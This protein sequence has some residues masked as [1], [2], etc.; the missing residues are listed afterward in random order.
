M[1]SKHD[2]NIAKNDIDVAKNTP[3]VVSSLSWFKGAK[4]VLGTGSLW[5]KC[6]QARGR[7][8]GITQS[9]WRNGMGGWGPW[10]LQMLQG[11]R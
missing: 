1:P 2:I 9:P 6:G 7:S 4:K 3:G 8:H 11:Q 5:Q 10:V